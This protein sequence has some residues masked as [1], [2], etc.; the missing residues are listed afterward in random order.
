M[1]YLITICMSW[2]ASGGL[3]LPDADL[4]FALNE[5]RRER[6]GSVSSKFQ[7]VQTSLLGWLHGELWAPTVA[8]LQ[9]CYK[10]EVKYMK[11]KG[12]SPEIIIRDG[13]PVAV[14]IDIDEYQEMLERIE[15]LEDLRALEEMRKNPQKFRKL[16]D[17][18]KEYNPGV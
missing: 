12:K 16:D 7:A 5:R 9:Q 13:K 2:E 17:F 6:I 3:R 8:H 14:I 18:L 4:V 1:R 10:L 11:T 15:D